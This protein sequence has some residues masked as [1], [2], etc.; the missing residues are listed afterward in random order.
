MKKN[1][2]FLAVLTALSM[3]SCETKQTEYFNT[4]FSDEYVSEEV[5]V[6]I[7]EPEFDEIETIDR[8]I[9]KEGK[10]KFRTSDANKTKLLIIQTVQELNGYIEIENAREYSD[11]FEQSLT[12]RVQADKLDILLNKISESV[13]KFESKNIEAID[14]TEEYID[15]EARIKTKKELQNR[16]SELLIGMVSYGL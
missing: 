14:V 4:S 15:I 7:S 5:P 11:R 1:M 10:I 16:Y 2:I 12:I 8:K 6:V 9:I 13:D 3:Y